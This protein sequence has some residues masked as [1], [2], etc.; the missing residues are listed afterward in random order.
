M[1]DPTRL[2]KYIQGITA[3]LHNVGLRM[4]QDSLEAMDRMLLESPVRRE[5]WVVESHTTKQMMTSLGVVTFRK[6]LFANKESGKSEYLLDQFLGLDRNERLTED[7]L[8][9]LLEEA[10]QTAYR[11][12]GENA[13]L[14]SGVSKQTVKNKLHHLEFPENHEKPEKKKKVEYL[15]IDADEDHISLQFREK[16]GE[17]TVRGNHQKNNTL[18]TKLV[19][20]YEGIEPES[21]KSRRHCLVTP[22]YFCGVN[23]GEGNQKFWDEVYDCIRSRYDLETVKKIYLNADGGGWIREGMERLAGVTCVLDGFHL[24]KHLTRLTAI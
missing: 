2:A 16:K 23:T 7:V 3:E 13:S 17:L 12:G 5:H 9:R 21:P 6:T 8:T 19:Y 22:H 11:R 24:K 20:V 14:T 1:K 15:Y 18:I 4:I 10:A